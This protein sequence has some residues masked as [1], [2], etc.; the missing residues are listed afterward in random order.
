MLVH[1]CCFHQFLGVGSLWIALVSALG[2]LC[3]ASWQNPGS[4]AAQNLSER[5][6]HSS[7]VRW[8]LPSAL[9]RAPLR[10]PDS[11]P[12]FSTLL[13]PVR[14]W[15]G[16]PR[17]PSGPSPSLL[18]QPFQVPESWNSLGTKETSQ[19]GG[20][21]A[22]NWSFCQ[23][24]WCSKTDE[25]DLCVLLRQHSGLSLCAGSSGGRFLLLK[26]SS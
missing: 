14:S 16:A 5:L 21:S 20:T 24:R 1:V 2:G 12:H 6:G 23:H 4:G 9:R 19:Q 17:S 13:V 3:D 18:S 25:F 7:V 8:T 15:T 26:L 22:G 11:F 10:R